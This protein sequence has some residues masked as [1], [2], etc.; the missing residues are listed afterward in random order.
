MLGH[1]LITIQSGPEGKPVNLVY[2]CERKYIRR[3]CYVAVMMDRESQGPVI[4]G[5]AV[6][7]VNIEILAKESPDQIV[8][9]TF[10]FLT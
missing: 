8:K 10:F 7:G 2:L 4:I 5:S 9:V 6:G 3:E 1:R